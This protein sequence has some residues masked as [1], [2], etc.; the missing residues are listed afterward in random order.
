MTST[1]AILIVDDDAHF[2]EIAA[3]VLKARGWRVLHATRTRDA[4]AILVDATP[5]IIVVDG[6]LPDMP[7]IEWIRARRARRQDERFAFVS[8]F[9]KDMASYN[10]LTRELGV[11]LIAYKPIDPEKLAHRIEQLVGPAALAAPP[12]SVA[13]A[14]DELR[15]QYAAGLPAMLTELRERIAKLA[16]DRDSAALDEVIADAHRLHGTSGTHRLHAVATPLRELEIRARAFRDAA[17]TDDGVGSLVA[18]LEHLLA[19]AERG[20]LDIQPPR[21][22]APPDRAA[23]LV[24]DDDRHFLDFAR[25]AGAAHLIDIVTA[26]NADEALEIAKAV[27]LAGAVIDIHLDAASGFDVARRLRDLEGLEALP[28]AFV[29]TSSSVTVRAEAAHAGGV[30]FL[31]KPTTEKHFG[32]VARR[33]IET[34]S[35]VEARALILDHDE[36][37]AAAISAIL[38]AEQINVRVIRNPGELLAELEGF[39]PQVL[40]TAADL[41]NIPGTDVCRATRTSTAFSNLPVIL[42]ADEAD[43]AF[44]V[45]LF[46]AGAD[47]FVTRPFVPEELAARVVRRVERMQLD[48]RLAHR[49]PT[50]GLLLRAA[51]SDALDARVREAERKGTLLTVC[52]LDLDHFKT[53]NDRYGHLSGDRVLRTV[54]GLLRRSFRAYDLRSRWGGEEFLVALTDVGAELATHAI[55]KVRAQL[56]VTPFSSDDGREFHVTFTAGLAEYPADGTDVRALLVAADRRLYRGK[57]TGRDRI[58]ASDAETTGEDQT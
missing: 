45:E 26:E 57:R 49:D 13:R 42:V 51:M 7:G 9:W 19:R 22:L 34:G 39:A 28:F 3:T 46:R 17:T 8:A 23:V 50:S 44:R 12:A 31:A 29:S 43:A 47:D 21:L 53:V 6:L 35:G 15:D 32:E 24:V 38:T 2:R 40:L 5:R 48:Q 18:L 54:G 20:L 10:L 4:D 52:L 1:E 33:L 14:L 25:V 27:P 41:P 55:D 56:A 30:A 16:R 36:D 11:E 37:R 58:V